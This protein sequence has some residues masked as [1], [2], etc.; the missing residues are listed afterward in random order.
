MAL[1]PLYSFNSLCQ[2]KDKTE[3]ENVIC[4]LVVTKEAQTL[5]SS[6][7]NYFYI[8]II[9]QLLSWND[10]NKYNLHYRNKIKLR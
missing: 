4:S 8:M 9:L 7:Y 10:I 5:I 2:N 3:W 6:T 1:P